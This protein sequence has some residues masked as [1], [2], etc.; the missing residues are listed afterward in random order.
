MEALGGEEESAKAKASARKLALLQPGDVSEHN[1]RVEVTAGS[2]PYG[3]G[4]GAEQEE[5]ED[6]AGDGVDDD[7]PD[8][9]YV[10]V[11]QRSFTLGE[12]RLQL[13]PRLVS[14]S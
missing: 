13:T 1:I 9:D 10:K 3:D 7:V 5:D 8:R 2:D 4:D 12:C 14:S 11:R 6:D